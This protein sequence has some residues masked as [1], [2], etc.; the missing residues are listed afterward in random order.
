MA[1]I[2][3][4]ATGLTARTKTI[5]AGDTTRLLAAYGSIAGQIALGTVP[6]T[7]R[8]RTNQE[9][10]DWFADKLFDRMKEDVRNIER[11]TAAKTVTDIGLS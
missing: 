5:S 7:Y 10:L 6:E 4:T 8:N 11:D 2:S 1:T 3:L 9:I